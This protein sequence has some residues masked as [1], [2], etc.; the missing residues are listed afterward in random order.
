VE[1]SDIIIGPLPF[2]NDEKYINT[3]FLNQ[4]ILISALLKLVKENQILFVGRINDNVLKIIDHY[5]IKFI[6]ILKREDMAI[7]NAVPTAE[8][9]IQIA[10]EE[11]EITLHDSNALVLG[12]G[13]IGKV[14]CKF[15]GGLGVNV[16]A[17]ARKFEDMAW[18]NNNSYNFVNIDQ[19]GDCVKKMDVIFNTIPS[20]ILGEDI[21]KKLKK[22]CLIVDLASVPGGVDFDKARELNVKTVWGLS[23]PGKVA[24]ITSA[25][26]LKKTIFNILSERDW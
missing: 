3:P 24:P 25:H 10:M 17:E 26:I 16:F 14:L 7:L 9:A 12:Y 21:L 6:D 23:L 22:D 13:R 5:N 19:I 2:S 8:G 15:L 4:R 18:I 20:K 11:L 1:N